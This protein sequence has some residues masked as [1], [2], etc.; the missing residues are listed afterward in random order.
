MN[1]IARGKWSTG[2]LSSFVFE[3]YL[4]YVHI[5]ASA[6][7][8][9]KVKKRGEERDHR[10]SAFRPKLSLNDDA[11]VNYN[12]EEIICISHNS[13]DSILKKL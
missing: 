12:Q 10:F 6:N 7:E 9:K 8:T 4:S 1:N 3:P 13:P 2:E 11:I 5:C